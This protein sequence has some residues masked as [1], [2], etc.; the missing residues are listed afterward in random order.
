M[1]RFAIR[2]ASANKH[3]NAIAD[4]L[5]KHGQP[6]NVRYVHKCNSDQI[7]GEC[8]YGNFPEHVVEEVRALPIPESAKLRGVDGWNV[9]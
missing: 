5:H 1:I 6:V 7:R 4:I 8:I 2:T 9:Q 3:L